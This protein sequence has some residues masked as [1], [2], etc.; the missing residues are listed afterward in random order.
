MPQL[1]RPPESASPRFDDWIFK[2]WQAVLGGGS[3]GDTGPVTVDVS[4][5][6][7]ATLSN[8]DS[9]AYSHL[10]A[11]NKAALVGGADTTL[12]FHATDRERGNHSGTQ[13]AATISDFT[14][15]VQAVIGQSSN[16]LESQVFGP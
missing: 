10:S 7:H 6:D 16:V 15:A 2:L 8:L 1:E 4:N 13:P 14:S 5:A 3:S 9:A 12:H 11:S